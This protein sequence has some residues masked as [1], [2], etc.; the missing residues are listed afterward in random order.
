MV[1]SIGAD[2]VIDYT[3][4]DFT[5]NEQHYDLFTQNEQRYDLIL[6]AGGYHSILDYKR[7]LGPEGIYVCA[8]GTMAQYFQAM[9]LGPSISMLAS[10]KMGVVRPKPNQKIWFS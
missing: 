8:G 4:E 7:A 1:R 9:L 10:E 5:Q 6:A 2:Q 3:Q